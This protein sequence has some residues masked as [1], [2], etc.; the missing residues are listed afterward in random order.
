[1]AINYFVP[2]DAMELLASDSSAKVRQL[3]AWK[4]SLTPEAQLA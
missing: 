2:A 3:V 1:V 4:A